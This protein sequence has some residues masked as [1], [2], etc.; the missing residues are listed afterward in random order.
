MSKCKRCAYRRQAYE[1]DYTESAQQQ[2][3]IGRSYMECI[4]CGHEKKR[5]SSPFDYELNNIPIQI[6]EILDLS[7]IV[8]KHKDYAVYDKSYNANQVYDKT[9]AC[10]SLD[11]MK[12]GRCEFCG[13][14]MKKHDHHFDLNHPSKNM[15]AETIQQRHLHGICLITGKPFRKI[16]TGWFKAK[17]FVEDGTYTARCSECNALLEKV[18]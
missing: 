18:K 13:K 2:R 9:G 5:T 3:V 17:H 6:Q 12:V 4:R 14:Q 16:E 15:K 10:I 7:K 1:I 11:K 8:H